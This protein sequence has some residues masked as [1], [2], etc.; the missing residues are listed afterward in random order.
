MLSY[1][2]LKPVRN[3]KISTITAEELLAALLE[4]TGGHLDNNLPTPKVWPLRDRLQALQNQQGRPFAS[5]LSTFRAPVIADRGLAKASLLLLETTGEIDAASKQNVINV[6]ASL[7][8]EAHRLED[9]RGAIQSTLK[10]AWEQ[11]GGGGNIPGEQLNEWVVSGYTPDVAA[12]LLKCYEG[13]RSGHLRLAGTRV[14]PADPQK[15][16]ELQTE[17]TERT[18]QLM[19]LQAEARRLSEKRAE[20]DVEASLMLAAIAPQRELLGVR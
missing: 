11:Y 16:A 13:C 20:L 6:A 18:A 7:E 9:Q 1:W 4:H 3:Y 15:P 17:G 2:S 8:A 12:S 10:E 5:K 19:E 14:V